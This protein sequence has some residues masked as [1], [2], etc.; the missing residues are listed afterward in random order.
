MA[1]ALA[2]WAGPWQGARLSA[3]GVRRGR[4]RG[5]GYAGAMP[6]ADGSGGG[7]ENLGRLRAWP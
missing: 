2:A 3:T 7:R 1:L 6:D 5:D 4:F